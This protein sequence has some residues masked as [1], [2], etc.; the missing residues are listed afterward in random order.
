MQI[1]CSSMEKC[2]VLLYLNIGQCILLKW[3]I[4][5][6][7]GRSQKCG[8]AWLEYWIGFPYCYKKCPVIDSQD[9]N[10]SVCLSVFV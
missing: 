5:I 7:F 4:T 3:T 2:Q 9:W 1:R 8:K 10:V 6:L